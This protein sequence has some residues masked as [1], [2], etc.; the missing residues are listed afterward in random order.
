MRCGKIQT[1]GN[2][3]REIRYFL[4]KLLFAL[5][6][7]LNF[8]GKLLISG[9][10]HHFCEKKRRAYTRKVENLYILSFGIRVFAR[11]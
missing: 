4:G 11:V 8:D 10:V 1:C 3:V 9:K 7:S 5:R 2:S 6:K